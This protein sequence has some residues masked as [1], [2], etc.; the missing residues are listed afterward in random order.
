MTTPQ[1]HRDFAHGDTEDLRRVLARPVN[2][3][4]LGVPSFG[5]VSSAAQNCAKAVDAL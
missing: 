2:P 4:D 1:T 3:T 5:D